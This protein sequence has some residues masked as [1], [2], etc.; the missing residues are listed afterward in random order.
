ML[1]AKVTKLPDYIEGPHTTGSVAYKHAER[2]RKESFG[3]A[4]PNGCF[5]DL[6]LIR[7]PTQ[8]TS[9]PMAVHFSASM[10]R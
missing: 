8:L 1:F 10:T 4:S 3:H 5:L 9:L 2:F 6:C 7:V